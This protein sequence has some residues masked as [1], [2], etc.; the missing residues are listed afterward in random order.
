MSDENKSHSHVEDAVVDASASGRHFPEPLLAD[1]RVPLEHV[2][3]QRDRFADTV[4][5]RLVHGFDADHRQNGAKYLLLACARVLR[6]V[7]LGWIG[8]GW[9]GL[10]WVGLVWCC[11]V[12]CCVVLCCVV[13]CCVVLCCVGL[14]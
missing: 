1:S 13:L 6:W 2:G 3:R 12:L 10:G 5:D 4:R 8:L 7:G 9:V 11:V 14:G